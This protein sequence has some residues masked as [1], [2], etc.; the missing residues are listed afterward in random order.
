MNKPKEVNVSNDHLLRAEDVAKKLAIAKPTVY[1]WAKKDI[2]PSVRFN[3]TIRFKSSDIA[4][5]IEKQVPREDE[6]LP[7]SP[8]PDPWPVGGW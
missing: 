4:R 1:L 3:R 2:L 7:Q 5:F 8:P 6:N